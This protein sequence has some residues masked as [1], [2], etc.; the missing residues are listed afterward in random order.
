[1]AG[2]L[3]TLASYASRA[4]MPVDPM[5]IPANARMLLKSILMPTN[6]TESNFRP[7]ELEALKQTYLNSQSRVGDIKNSYY[8]DWLNNLQ[9]FSSE[10]KVL[11]KSPDTKEQFVPQWQEKEEMI[12]RI[13]PTIQYFDYPVNE[14]YKY[15]GVGDMPVSASFTDPSYSMST[16]IGRAKYTTDD[17]GNVHVIDQYDFP[18][19]NKMQDYGSW[20]V[21]FKAAHALGE[22]YSNK[23]PVDINLGKIKSILDKKRVK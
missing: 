12:R 20:S 4:S 6:V 16:T 9:G 23:M 10:D 3:D 7:D 5:L 21:P 11:S 19:G 8:K 18:R 13:S 2:L 14:K 1:M 22:T 15:N 17:Q